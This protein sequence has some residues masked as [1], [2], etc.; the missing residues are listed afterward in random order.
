MA[1]EMVKRYA[2]TGLIW[3]LL[4]L[5]QMMQGKDDAMSALQKATALLPADAELHNH[6]GIALTSNEQFSKAEDSFRRAL[7]IKPD[8]AEAYYNLNLAYMAQGR[9]PE[10]EKA[11]RQAIDN[12]PGYALAHHGLGLALKAR[13]DLTGAETS[14]RHALSLKPDFAGGHYSLGYLLLEQ[15]RSIEAEASFKHAVEIDPDYH[16]A[17]NKLGLCYG[18]QGRFDDA[19]ASYHH[20]LASAPDNIDARFN[21]AVIRKSHPGDD[22][23]NAMLALE[24][25]HKDGKKPLA[26]NQLI[27]LN[28]ALGRTF[29]N[30]QEYD[31]A[32]AYYA[33]GARRKRATFDYSAQKNTE[34]FTQIAQFFNRERLEKLAGSGDPSSSPIFVLGMPR[35]GTTLIEQI[36]ASHR[37]VHGA[38]EL[39][40]LIDV[41]TGA[42]G[43]QES[44]FPQ[45][46]PTLDGAVL[47]SLGAEYLARVRRHDMQAARITD[48]QPLN[49]IAA[50][51]IHLML[52]NAK[53]IH[54]TRNPVDTCLSCFSQLFQGKMEFSYDLT[55]LGKYY[56]DY[57]ALMEHW[58]HV[59][60]A[61]S[62]IDVRYEE[63]VQNPEAQARR[64]IDY[65]DL[66]WDA[67]CLNFHDSKR[68]I[69]TASVFQARQPVYRSSVERWRHYERHL[70]PLLNALGNLVPGR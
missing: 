69:R 5:S 43:A 50:G 28:F 40:D 60:P 29:E 37:D 58:R 33:E 8:Y 20:V 53:I 44:R 23:T 26:D 62:F 7:K 56:V 70:G 52:P 2:D 14:L 39:P 30:C 18:E 22:N 1:H 15:A 68:T 6:L 27:M 9:L 25:A 35:S 46:L 59:L 21:L 51:L 57:H 19:E 31:R 32:F 12:R 17:R 4:G 45:A 13:G 3:K 38:G 16:E 61:G 64:L 48:K 67:Q 10:A 55:E 63:V 41:A 49:F 11:L 24:Q 36:I 54:V 34:R 66:E 47:A 42:V 65:C